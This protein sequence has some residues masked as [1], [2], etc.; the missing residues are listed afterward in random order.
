MAPVSIVDFTGRDS[1]VRGGL[2]VR[3]RGL[4]DVGRP[5]PNPVFLEVHEVG[6]PLPAVKAPR[7]RMGNVSA[8]QLEEPPIRAVLGTGR[9]SRPDNGVLAV[10][11]GLN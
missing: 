3:P 9:D 4:S 11:L 5:V 7:A 1:R 10:M 8:T 2:K 6:V